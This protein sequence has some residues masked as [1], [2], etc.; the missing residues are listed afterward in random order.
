MSGSIIEARRGSFHFLRVPMLQ[1]DFFMKVKLSVFRVYWVSVIA[2]SRP[3]REQ[4]ARDLAMKCENF[5]DV[6]ML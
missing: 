5:G 4:S 2:P 6:I 1:N 3:P